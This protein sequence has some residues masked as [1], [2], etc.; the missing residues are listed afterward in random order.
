MNVVCVTHTPISHTGACTRS[1]PQ[2]PYGCGAMRCDVRAIAPIRRPT[3]RRRPNAP[4]VHWSARFAGLYAMLNLRTAI[5]LASPFVHSHRTQQPALDGAGCCRT[6]VHP[7]P[8]PLRQRLNWRLPRGEKVRAL[9]GW[10]ALSL[11]VVAVAQRQQ[12]EKMIHRG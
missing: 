6:Q 10:L 7:S 12:I 11:A 1:A 4:V 8:R 9:A 2:N 3:Q 5:A